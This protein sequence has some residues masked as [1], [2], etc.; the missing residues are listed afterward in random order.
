MTHTYFK[1][2]K[3][4][5]YSNQC[6]LV[7]YITC[8]QHVIGAIVKTNRCLSFASV[9]VTSQTLI[10][11]YNTCC[12]VHI[13]REMREYFQTE[14]PSVWWQEYTFMMFNISQNMY[15]YKKHYHQSKGRINLS[16]E[17]STAI[18]THL[19]SV[20]YKNRETY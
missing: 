13:N 2:Y 7:P 4:Y 15:V 11:K 5:N 6:I 17:Y 1:Y 3:F 18:Y 16:L 12:L 14:A 20:V 19:C 10:G 8:G 9:R